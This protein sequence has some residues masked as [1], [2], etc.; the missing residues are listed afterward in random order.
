MTYYALWWSTTFLEREKKVLLRQKIS[1]SVMTPSRDGTAVTQWWSKSLV[2]EDCW[3][4]SPGLHVWLHVWFAVSHFGQ[5]HLLKCPSCDAFFFAFAHFWV[6]KMMWGLGKVQLQFF[7][8]AKVQFLKPCFIFWKHET[9]NL[10]FK[11]Y[12][13]NL[14]LLMQN[15]TLASKQIYLCSKPNIA[16][17]L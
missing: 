11:H 17:K 1:H 6:W 8:I 7:S 15:E 9:Q 3:L 13:Q 14:R 10:S 5:K 2:V 12:L 4:Y 16:L